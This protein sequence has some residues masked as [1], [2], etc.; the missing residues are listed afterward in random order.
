MNWFCKM[1][2]RDKLYNFQDFVV[3]DRWNAHVCTTSLIYWLMCIHSWGNRVCLLSFDSIATMVLELWNDRRTLLKMVFKAEYL[4]NL[5]WIVW[6]DSMK[7]CEWL[8]G[9]EHFVYHSMM[10]FLLYLDCE[11]LYEVFDLWWWCC[12]YWCE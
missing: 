9:V 7:M 12:W 3:F 2:K 5:L 10:Y 4:T 11:K 6:Y 8:I 1:I